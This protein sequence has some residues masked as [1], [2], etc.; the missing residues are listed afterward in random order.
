MWVVLRACVCGVC[1][2]VWCTGAGYG[3]SEEHELRYI[4]DVARE[5][6]IMPVNLKLQIKLAQHLNSRCGLH[7][8][9]LVPLVL[10]EKHVSNPA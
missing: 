10:G 1:V 2:C 4:S 6:G 9:P 5:T 7:P 8:A 3:L